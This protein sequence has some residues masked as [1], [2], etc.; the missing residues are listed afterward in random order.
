MQRSFLHR[1]SLL[2]T[3]LFLMQTVCGMTALADEWPQWR[4]AGRDGIWTETG[5]LDRFP[6]PEIEVKWRVPVSSGYSG[7][8]VADGRVYLTDRIH[9]P[10]EQERVHCFDWETGETL[11]SFTYDAPYEGLR[12]PAGPRA[13]V[14]IHDGRAYALGAVGHF[15]C[16]DA[17]DGTL[18]W[19][20]DLREEYQI[21]MP[22]WGIAAAPLIEEDRVIVQI[23]GEGACLVAFDRITGE[24]QWKALDDDAS[25]SA[26]MMIEQAGQRVLLCWTGDRIVGLNPQSGE[27]HWAFPFPWKSWPIGIATPVI[28]GE[29]LLFS[30]AHKGALLLKAPADRLSIEQVWHRQKEDDDDEPALHCLISTPIIR[31][32]HIY[33]ADN[34]G[35]L[36]CLDLETG[37]QIWE[38]DSAVPQNRFATIHLIE[39]GDADDRIWM[40]NE[41][42][43]LIISRLSPDGFEELS[44]AKLLDPTTEQLRRRDGVTWS[45]PA[46][47]HRH[48]FA[49]NDKELVCADLSA[50][51]ETSE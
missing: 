26:P 40:F 6:S 25:Y 17:A 39:R 42:G 37:R 14:T 27:E 3:G 43:E 12:Y 1:T 23:G 21:R 45:H 5:I 33:G 8:T 11:W 36:R 44:R 30:E 18:L 48:V 50:Q 41:R 38:D 10:E 32:G 28:H 29:L 49:R 2:A 9:E 51:A 15:H 24:E 16:F 22:N 4:G 34:E 19:N 13:A 7:P 35:I 20:R 31:D 46:F 47:A